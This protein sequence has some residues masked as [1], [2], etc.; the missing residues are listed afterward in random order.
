M[1]NDRSEPRLPSATPERIVEVL[2]EQQYLRPHQSVGDAVAAT[3]ERLGVC[4]DAAGRALVALGLSSV[5]L[6]GRLRRTELIQ[7][8]RTVHRL[9]RQNVVDAAGQSQPA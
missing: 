8:G 7:L 5:V 4:P 9:W 2:S 6:I 1:Q 3:I